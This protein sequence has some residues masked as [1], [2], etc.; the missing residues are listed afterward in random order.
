MRL[1]S[2]SLVYDA[3]VSR[4]RG[5]LRL[6]VSVVTAEEVEAALEGGADVVDVKNP[7]EGSLGAAT[8]ALLRAIRSLVTP[9]VLSRP[10]RRL[11]G[12]GARARPHGRPCRRPPPRGFPRPPL[13][14]P[15]PRRCPGKCL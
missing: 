6:L 8:P 10:G 12:R 4:P 5:A 7:A 15:G 2:R 13:S 3:A 14:R 9:P 11:R 1:G